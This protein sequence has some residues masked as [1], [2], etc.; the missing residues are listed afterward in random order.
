MKILLIS[1]L[2]PIHDPRMF[3]KFAKSLSGFGHEVHIAGFGVCGSYIP[4][5]IAPQKSDGNSLV[6]ENLT[7]FP[8]T[9]TFF[10]S[11]FFP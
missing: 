1:I 8:I 5:I 11:P 2:K 10:I 7:K 9:F 6:S 4:E 3:E